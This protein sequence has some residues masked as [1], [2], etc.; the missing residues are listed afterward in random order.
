MVA[1]VLGVPIV[2]AFVML[3]VACA[4][5]SVGLIFSG[6]MRWPGY[7]RE[8]LRANL[9]VAIGTAQTP[10]AAGTASHTAYSF[11][12]SRIEHRHL[13]HTAICDN[14]TAVSATLEWI[15]GGVRPGSPDQP[16][17]PLALQ[18]LSA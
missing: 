2:V 1:L 7:W 10:R 5:C 18:A 8:P 13:R 4:I 11:E 14:A 3:I 9:L 17:P 12:S 6:I 16:S 15:S